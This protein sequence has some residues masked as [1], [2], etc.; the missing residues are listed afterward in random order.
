MIETTPF[1]SPSDAAEYE[2]WLDFVQ[3]DAEGRDEYRAACN[4]VE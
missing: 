3:S 2:E 4:E 1:S